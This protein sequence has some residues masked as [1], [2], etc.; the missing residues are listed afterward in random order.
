MVGLRSAD[1]TY[2]SNQFALDMQLDM[3][4]VLG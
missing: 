2:R 1:E 4:W 3:Q